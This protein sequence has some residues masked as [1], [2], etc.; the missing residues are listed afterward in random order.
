MSDQRE[1]V[2]SKI[3]LEDESVHWDLANKS[4]YGSYLQLDRLLSA[5]HPRSDAHDEMMFIGAHQVSEL[6]I[7]MILHEVSGV[8][9]CVRSGSLGPAFK[10]LSRV[11]RI[12]TQLTEVWSI[13]ATMTPVD[14]A[15]FR[16]KLG[17]ASGFQSYQYRVLEFTLG[18]KNP[19]MIAV[20][21]HTPEIYKVVKKSLDSPSLYDE[22]LRLLSRRD[23]QI[24][25]GKLD[26]DWAQPYEEDPAVEA[27]WTKVYT[28][29]SRYWDLYELAEKLIDI[30][31]NFQQ[32]RFRHMKTVA[33]IIGMKRGTGGTSG[34]A[35]LKKALS[36]RF[37]PE[38]WSVRSHV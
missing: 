27:A 34:V 13:V 29:P 18:N 8:L 11:A 38:L 19:S 21:K 20:H 37:F 22:T 15:T 23:L 12:Q 25:T 35:Y 4:N 31:D 1:K 5:Q 26:R 7:K 16:D 30:E 14:Y 32:W 24:P 2:I 17:E 36:L 33:R 3:E 9:D 28:N 10:M 6:W